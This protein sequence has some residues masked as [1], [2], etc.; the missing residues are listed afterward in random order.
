MGQKQ[1]GRYLIEDDYDSEFRYKGRP[2]PALQGMDDSQKVI[3]MGT[4]P[5]PLL[6][7]SV[8]ALW[9]FRSRCWLYTG[10]SRFY[11][12]TVSRV[13]QNI[14]THFIIEGYYERH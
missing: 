14:L 9:Y 6:R 2:I 1:E 3:Y 11:A 5:V 13:D 12:S 4:F 8:W 10:K 7:R